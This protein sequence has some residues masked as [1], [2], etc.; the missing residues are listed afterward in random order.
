MDPVIPILVSSFTYWYNLL[1]CQNGKPTATKLGN[2]VQ[3]EDRLHF[4]HKSGILIIANNF[5]ESILFSYV[6]TVAFFPFLLQIV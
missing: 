6:K 5:F 4:Y 3:F 1:A 2:H